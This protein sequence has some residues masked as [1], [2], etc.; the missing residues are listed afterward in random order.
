MSSPRRP[1]PSRASRTV[2]RLTPAL[3]PL[4][5]AGL[6]TGCTSKVPLEPAPDATEAACADVVVHLPEEVAG[7]RSRETDAQGTAAWGSPDSTVLLRC[8]VDV[9]GPTTERCIGVSGVD[10]V[11]DD[12]RQPLMTYT[13]Y[14]RSPAVE[15]FVN[16]DPDGGISGSSVLA[17][18]SDAIGGSIK[19]TGGCTDPAELLTTEPPA[20][21]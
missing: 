10:W 11:I 14:G 4:L 13:T 19:A 1:R 12:S 15:V 6:L 3:V 18:L 7:Q 5:A 8:G 17:A 20:A 9:P 2:R 21:P 16:E